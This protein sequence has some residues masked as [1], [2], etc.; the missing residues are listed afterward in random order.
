LTSTPPGETFSRP[1]KL[2]ITE[3]PNAHGKYWTWVHWS[4][5]VTTADLFTATEVVCRAYDVSQ[6]TQ[7]A[8]LTWSLLGQGNNCMFRLRLHKEVDPAGRL[9][10]RFQQ[11]APILP[12]AHPAAAWREWRSWQRTEPLTSRQACWATWA[13]ARRRRWRVLHCR[14]R[15]CRLRRP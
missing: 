9:C 6:N 13:G 4:L 1:C 11:P 7:P 10:I 8:A 15:L 5:E 12:G 14:R 2:L 3:T